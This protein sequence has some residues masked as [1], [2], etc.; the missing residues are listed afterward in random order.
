MVRLS[1]AGTVADE[2]NTPKIWPLPGQLDQSAAHIPLWTE[3]ITRFA[4]RENSI[5][6]HSPAEWVKKREQLESMGG[7]PRP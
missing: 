3:V 6:H 2:H 5:R 7:A 1:S 4:I